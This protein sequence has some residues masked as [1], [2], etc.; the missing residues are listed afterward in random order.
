[1]D[2][3][4]PAA[5][6]GRGY[7]PDAREPTV[8]DVGGVAPT[9]LQGAIGVSEVIQPPVLVFGTPFKQTEEQILDLLGDRPGLAVADRFS[10]D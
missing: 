6:V 1:M 9:Y 2:L 10:V 4:C 7:V 8:P 3:V 5:S